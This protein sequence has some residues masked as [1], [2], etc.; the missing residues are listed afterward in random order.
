MTTHKPL[1]LASQSP[2]RLELLK[3][4]GINAE[5][6]PVSADA[7]LQLGIDETP[8][9]N[10]TPRDYVQ[11]IC[12]DK[13][14]AGWLA[15]QRRN[16]LPPAPVLAADTTVALNGDTLGKPASREEAAAML[17]RLSG[18]THEVLSAVAITFDG[19]TESRLSITTVDF[20]PLD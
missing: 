6:L 3:L 10:E 13:V 14:Q 7:H 19:R 15:L 9:A 16:D 1:Y 11:R 20:I 12:A 18:R 4:V 2:R 5:I 17:R 8:F